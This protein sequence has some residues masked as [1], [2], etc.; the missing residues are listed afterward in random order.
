MAE[1]L[2]RNFTALGKGDAAIAGGKG[3]SLGEMIKAG[4]PVPPGFVLLSGAFERFI[5]ETDITTKIDS[6]LH[7][8]N[9][10][11]MHT[12][13]RA[14]ATIQRMILEA[15]MP[16]DIATEIKKHFKELDAEFV[17]VRSSATAEDSASAA[18]AGQLDSFL[19]TDESTLLKNV[20]QCWASLFTPRAIFYRFEKELHLTKIS[21]AVVVQKMVESEVSGIA[22]SVHPVTEDRNQ[23][24]IEAGF[25]LGEA[26]VSGQV[27]PDSYV[28]EKEP[29]RIIDSN[30]STQTRALY[31]SAEGGNEWQDIPE[32]KAS[33]QVLTENQILEL[34]EIILK[35]ENHYGFPCDI[36]WAFEG[37]KFYI[38]QSRP[39]TTLSATITEPASTGTPKAMDI[40]LKDFE[41]GSSEDWNEQGKW[42]LPPFVASALAYHH[43]DSVYVHELFPGIKIKS[44]FYLGGYAF[45][46]KKD[47]EHIFSYV[48]QLY[49]EHKL[50]ELYEK[51]DALG[52]EITDTF[53][54]ELDKD[55]AYRKKNAVHILK[56]YRDLN[57][58]WVIQSYV[59]D[60]CINLAKDIKYIQHDQELF[61]KV[62][63]FL[64]DTWIERETKDTVTIAR[65]C[66]DTFKKYAVTEE[67]IVGDA[68]IHASVKKYIQ[69]YSWS[70]MS[71]WI[72]EP[73]TMVDALERINQEIKNVRE[74]N[75]LETFKNT[76]DQMDGLV[77][78]SVS[79]SF[80]RAE[81]GMLVMMAGEKMAF[82]F[83]EIATANA[84]SKEEALL[85]TF[86][87]VLEMVQK[88]DM[89][90]SHLDMV[91]KRNKEYFLIGD[92]K[93]SVVVFGPE[94]VRYPVLKK[95]FIHAPVVSK[96]AVLTGVAASPGSVRAL[97]RVIQSSKE[98]DTFI[99]GEIL[100]SVETSP[101]FVPLMRK[102]AAILTGKGGITS[103][104]AIVSREL[105]KPCIIAIPDIIK[106]LKTGDLV[107]VDANLGVVRIVQKAH[108]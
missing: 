11:E 58:F 105:K 28:V 78:I 38:V 89:K 68:N 43:M 44:F 20:Q 104:A 86:P 57:D 102:A 46:H 4:I 48:K 10:E 23:L 106:I 16:E 33:S 79:S 74:G 94:D 56:M 91:L 99:E 12:V 8:V 7:E 55:E 27:T 81:G 96:D 82:I 14:S 25:G 62:Q 32:P 88:R 51:I 87:E 61:G 84:I 97:V 1:E 9:R 40:F 83:D 76:T 64:R 101:M 72:G 60:L 92:N 35:I 108:E 67:D 50:E 70:K 26:I 69:K 42:T 19:N 53:R 30:V 103:H 65:L 59:G 6:E 49:S 63:P 15:K 52:N 54:V 107:E 100:V 39:I 73:I 21:V 29:R 3:A 45:Q 18:W 31:R 5:E 13:E 77:G 98:F 41:L 71:W 24:I 37:G 85:L 95:I 80:W 22:F 66:L 36:E 90:I 93:G 34:S 2:I 75:H 47:I 17:A